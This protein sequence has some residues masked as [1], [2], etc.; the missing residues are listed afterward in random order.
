MKM[1]C[2]RCGMDAF[3]PTVCHA[4]LGPVETIHESSDKGRSA[5]GG[6]WTAFFI[7]AGL[8]LLM[9]VSALFL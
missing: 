3:N 8:G 7:L 4:C 1:Q 5:G 2:T 9:Q 6:F